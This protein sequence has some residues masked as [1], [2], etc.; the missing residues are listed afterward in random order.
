M[1]ALIE[2]GV[3]DLVGDPRHHPGEELELL[4]LAPLPVRL[5]LQREVLEHDHRA[6]RRGAVAEDGIGRHFQ[7]QVAEGELH[8]LAVHRAVAGERLEEHVAQG[9][10]QRAQISV[11]HV[12]GGEAEDLLGAAVHDHHPL[13]GS[14]RDHAVRHRRGSAR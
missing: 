13:V 12:A 8:L 10:R 9:A 1:K 4:G 6:D 2:T 7:R 14:D 11:Q 3:L 5:A